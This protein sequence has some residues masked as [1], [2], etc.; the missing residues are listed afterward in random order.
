MYIIGMRTQIGK[1]AEIDKNTFHSNFQIISFSAR[2]KDIPGSRLMETGLIIVL[3]P[4][5]F[6]VV[7][8]I[9]QHCYT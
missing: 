9:I 7:N 2:Q 3:L 5:F 8:N 4:T 6:N 1:E